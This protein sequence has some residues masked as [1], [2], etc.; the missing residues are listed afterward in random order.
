[1]KK[2]FVLGDCHGRVKALKEVLKKSKF[3]YDRDKL[4]VIG[5][6]V[7]GGINTYKV[8]EELLKIKNLIFI[9]GNHDEWFLDHIKSGWSG[10]IWLSQGGRNTLKSYKDKNIPVTHQDFLNKAKYYHIEDDML[11]VHGGFNP[12]HPIEEQPKEVLVWDRMLIDY[13]K[14]E[15]IKGY[16]KIFIGHTTTQQYSD[17]LPVRFNNLIMTDCGAGFN[18]KLCLMNIKTEKYWLSKKQ[19]P[20]GR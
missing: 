9:M 6:I 10:E 18:G 1:M 8:I 12:K 2:I 4:I 15:P 5:D 13:A 16:K 17:C 11:F 3:D 20:G 14:V 7:D 19:E